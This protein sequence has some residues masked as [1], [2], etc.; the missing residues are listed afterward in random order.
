MLTIK[1]SGGSANAIIKQRQSNLAS[2]KSQI[3]NECGERL[4]GLAR[5]YFDNLSRGGTGFTGRSWAPPSAA[6]VRKRQSLA[7]RGLLSVPANVQ[8]V[9]TG[10]MQRSLRYYTSDNAVRVYYETDYAAVFNRHRR[11]IP[12]RLPKVWRTELNEIVAKNVQE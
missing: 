9:V 5:I 1:F 10:S 7:R 2:Q 8:G 6:T 4:V 3:L 12:T 11:L